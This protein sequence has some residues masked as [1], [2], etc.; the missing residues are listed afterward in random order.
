MRRALGILRTHTGKSIGVHE[1]A[2]MA[3]VSRTRLHVLFRERLGTSPHAML[4]DLRL[5][6]AR[7][8]LEATALPIAEI[9]TRCGFADQN[10]LTRWCRRSLG[11][12]PA[13][14]RRNA[15]EGSA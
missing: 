1:V 8:L 2:E 3:G 6:Q 4:V 5:R 7:R 14:I 12:T 15:R 13:V 10:G 11:L 9:A